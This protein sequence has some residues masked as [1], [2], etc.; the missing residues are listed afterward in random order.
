MVQHLREH[1][2]E[3]VAFLRAKAVAEEGER[4]GGTSTV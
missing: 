4:R 2:S 1:K 3:L